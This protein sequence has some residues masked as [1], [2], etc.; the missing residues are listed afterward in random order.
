MGNRSGLP[1]DTGLQGSGCGFLVGTCLGCSPSARHT[2]QFTMLIM[3][4]DFK[5]SAERSLN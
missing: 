1:T 2:F 5:P 4:I 3:D